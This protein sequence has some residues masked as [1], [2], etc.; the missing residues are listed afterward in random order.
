[1]INFLASTLPLSPSNLIFEFN[2]TSCP[3]K[4]PGIKE[5]IKGFQFDK[6]TLVPEIGKNE[7][8][9][10]KTR[11]Y[12]NGDENSISKNLNHPLAKEIADIAIFGL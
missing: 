11:I 12:E 9:K 7:V 1:M 10:L 4:K 5:I 6:F 8:K 3:M 2:H